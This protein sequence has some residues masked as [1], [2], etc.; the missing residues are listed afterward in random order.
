MTQLIRY[1]LG[2]GLLAVGPLVHAGAWTL[3]ENDN[4][5]KVAINYF[6][7]TDTFGPAAEGF[8][9][10]TDYTIN[11][12][13][14]F[15]LTDKVTFITQVPLRQSRNST[16]TG[17]AETTGIGDIDLGFRLNLIESDW[18]VSTIPP[19]NR[20]TVSQGGGV[21]RPPILVGGSYL[22]DI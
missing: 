7:A 9:K 2:I 16:V 10:F 15:G 12:Y 6:E 1:S 19:E 13:G 14:E 4:Y 5:N 8:E 18:V 21:S 22:T 11:Y 20:Y 17:S 3:K